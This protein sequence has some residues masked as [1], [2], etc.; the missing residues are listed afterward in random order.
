MMDAVDLRSRVVKTIADDDD[1]YTGIETME[2][3]LAITL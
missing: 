3:N 2:G 1:E